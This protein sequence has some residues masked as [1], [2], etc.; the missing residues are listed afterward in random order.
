M[1][2]LKSFA[3]SRGVCVLLVHHLR[4]MADETDV[5]NRV[6]GTAGIVGA[7]DTVLVLSRLMRADTET[8]L[9]VVGRDV[10]CID[11]T[12]AFDKQTCRWSVV[13]GAEERAAQ[14]ERERFLADPL[15]RTITELMRTH[16]A[17]WSGTASELFACCGELTHSF[18]DDTPAAMSKRLKQLSPKLF[19]YKRILYRAPAQNGSNGKRLHSLCCAGQPTLLED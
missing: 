11:E 9:S 17:G 2:R 8:T 16:P 10:E 1:G 12:L 18:P 6:S 15:V 19:E 4:K 7:A 3:D 5:F 14:A 13:P